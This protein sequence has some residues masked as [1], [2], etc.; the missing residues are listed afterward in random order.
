ML[1]V[2]GTSIHLTRG[3]TLNILIGLTKNKKPYVLGINDSMSFAL[4]RN[5][6]LSDNSDFKDSDPLI[7]KEIPT[8]TRIL[9]LDSSDTADL[10]FGEY[11]YDIKLTLEDGTVDT[12]I[13]NAKFYLEPEVH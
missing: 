8:D 4:K 10:K 13:T 7:L 12:V 3:D 6:L 11:V 9:H 2:E 5:I 1:R